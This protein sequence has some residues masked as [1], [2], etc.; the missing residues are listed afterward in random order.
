MNRGTFLRR[1]LSAL[2]IVSILIVSAVVCAEVKLYT[3]TAEDYANEVESQDVAKLRARDKAI[4]N[5]TKQ[6][7]VYLKSYSRS[8]NGILTD[9]DI[10]AVTSNAWQLVGEPTYTRTINKI[11]D[12]TTII[13]WKAT[14]EVNVDDA[15]LL[16]W[17]KR[18]NKDKSTIITQTLAAQRASEEND[19]QIEDLR[20]QYKRATTQA[21]RDSIIRR[22]NQADRDF[23]ANQKLEEGNRLYYESKF[24]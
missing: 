6:A 24:N 1:T 15:E 20:E 4:K 3:A 17:I 11:S 10:L 21:E 13:V 19:K 23:L 7:G 18:D 14:V 5:A 9:D 2:V 12:E 16:S 8:L 22:M